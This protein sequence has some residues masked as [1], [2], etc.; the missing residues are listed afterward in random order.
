MGV[1]AAGR[2]GRRSRTEQQ[3]DLGTGKG[4]DFSRFTAA[5]PVKLAGELEGSRAW[6]E[7]ETGAAREQGSTARQPGGVSR[8]LGLAV[9]W[10]DERM[11]AT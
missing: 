7:Q 2:R 1:G 11:R 6:P 5:Q 9:K 3:V 8:L 4:A 10:G